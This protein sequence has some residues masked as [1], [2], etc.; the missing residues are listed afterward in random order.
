M[1]VFN[2]HEEICLTTLI[3]LILVNI[4]L[5]FRVND[6]PIDAAACDA[7]T[8]TTELGNKRTDGSIVVVINE[9]VSDDEVVMEKEEVPETILLF[10]NEDEQ[11]DILLLFKYDN[12]KAEEERVV[13]IVE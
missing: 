10:T 13:V 1:V 11:L 12:C 9:H 6:W 8:T 2:G 7:E 4:G 3:G 5:V